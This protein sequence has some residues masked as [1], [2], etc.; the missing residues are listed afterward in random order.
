MEA[1][2]LVSVLIDICLTSLLVVLWWFYRQR[3]KDREDSIKLLF[4]KHDDD[5]TEL[6]NLKLIIASKH[7][8][9]TDLDAKFDKMEETTRHGFKDMGEKFDKLSNTL[10]DFLAQVNGF[11]KNGR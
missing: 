7:Y 5:V 1:P 2:S 8:E 4:K 9:R 3:D 11:G 10:M 6:N